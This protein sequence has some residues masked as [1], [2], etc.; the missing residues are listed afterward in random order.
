MKRALCTADRYSRGLHAWNA[1]DLKTAERMFRA[2]LER[3]PRH[4]EATQHLGLVAQ[5]TGRLRLASRLLEA[6]VQAKPGNA[7][8][9]FNLG[10]LRFEQGRY[11]EALREWERSARLDPR[12]EAAWRNIALTCAER[13]MLE[14]A[15]EAFLQAL[16]LNPDAADICRGLAALATREG[17][18]QEAGDWTARAWR[19]A[20]DPDALARFAGALR[21]MGRADQSLQA[22]RRAIDLRPGDARLHYRLAELLVDMGRQPAAR[23]ECRRALAL[24]PTLAAASFLEDSLVRRRPP[25]PPSGLLVGLFNRFAD[26]FDSTLVDHLCYR[27]PEVIW[28]TVQRVRAEHAEPRVRLQVLDAGCGTGLGAR[29]LRPAASRLVGIDISERMLAKAQERGGYDQLLRGELV[30]HLRATP[31]RYHLVF[32]A[33]VFVYLGDLEPVMRAVRHALRPGGLL[34]FSVE[35]CEGGSYRLNPSQRYA[36]SLGYI[37]G[38]AEANHLAVRSARGARLRYESGLPVPSWVVVLQSA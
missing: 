2:V 12:D 7:R 26:T 6:S 5:K 29:F 28:R 17:R 38:L 14:R 22:L 13:G 21:G 9:A 35:R 1:G 30:E 8:F 31:R 33:D 15:Q 32:A 24:D 10:N 3:L 36:H 25:T 4:A 34:A 18:P 20:Q 11:A 16:R 37:R 27:G 23:R 19:L